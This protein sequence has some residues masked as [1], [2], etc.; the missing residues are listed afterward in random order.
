M[1]FLRN[2]PTGQTRRRIFTH[3]GSNDADSRKDV[4]FGD[5]FHTAPH[6]GGKNPQNNFGAW[7]SVFKPNSR[8][9]K[10]V[11]IIKNTASIPPKFCI[12][13]NRKIAI[14]RPQLQWFQRNL[15]RWCSSTLVTI[16]SVINFKFQKLAPYGTGGRLLLTANFEVT[17]HKNYNKN[18]KLGPKKL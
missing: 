18:Q 14:S 15:A 16:W 2:S 17:W 13:K 10:N 6:L 9:Q 3:D 12:L 8:S 7:I 11:H 5:I 4:P 1:P